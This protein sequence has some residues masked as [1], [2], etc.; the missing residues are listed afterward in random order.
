M[1]TLISLVAVGFSLVSLTGCYTRLVTIDHS[2][3]MYEKSETTI[4]IIPPP[5]PPIDPCICAEPPEPLPP[6]YNPSPPV[7]N[8][9]PPQ[10]IRQPNNPPRSNDDGGVRDKLRGSGSRNNSDGRNRK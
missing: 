2:D 6:P 3:E 7:F 8:P 9:N 4:V 10:K 5:Q 1:K